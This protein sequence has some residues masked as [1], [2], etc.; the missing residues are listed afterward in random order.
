MGSMTSFVKEELEEALRAI[1]STL[2][3]SEKVQLKL[4]EGTFHHTRIVREIRSYGIAIA[5][6]E[7][8]LEAA[9]TEDIFAEEVLQEALQTL[10]SARSRVEKVVPKFLSGTSQHTLAVRRCQAFHL[11]EDLIRREL[12]T[13]AA[14]NSHPGVSAF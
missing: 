6:M 12:D 11:A 4:Q 3:K 2:R 5:L 8:E 1:I 9:R 7:R 14:G 10:A 13:P